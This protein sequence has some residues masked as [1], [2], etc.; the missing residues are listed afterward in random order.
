[1]NKGVD[2]IAWLAVATLAWAVVA[3]LLAMW[4]GA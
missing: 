3:V 2:F 1:M 4:I